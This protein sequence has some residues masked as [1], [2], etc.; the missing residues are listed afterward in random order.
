MGGRGNQGGGG[1]RKPTALEKKVLTYGAFEFDKF[2][3]ENKDELKKAGLWSPEG[4]EKVWKDTRYANSVAGAHV[5]PKEQAIAIVMEK[6]PANVRDGWFRQA[7]STYKPSIE[8]LAIGSRDLRNAGLNIA[9]RNYVEATGSKLTFKQF[10]DTDLTVY[11]G[12]NFKFVDADTFVSYS[13]FKDVAAK[14]GSN[15]QMIKIKR[16]GS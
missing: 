12:G 2:V 9:Y 11:R 3:R 15:V 10:I 4:A 1:G 7:D 5:V 14:F 16:K 13:F 6:M 8:E